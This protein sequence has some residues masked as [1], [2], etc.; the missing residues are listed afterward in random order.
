MCIITLFF[1]FLMIRR[2]PRSTLFP[3]T[4][5]FRSNVANHP[6]PGQSQIEAGDRLRERA[7]HEK[8]P[9]P[10]MKSR[11]AIPHAGDQL[12]RSGN[13]DHHGENNMPGKN[14]VAHRCSGLVSV[15]KDSIPRLKIPAQ[16]RKSIER[17][18]R[19]RERELPDQ[20]HAKPESRSRSQRFIRNRTQLQPRSPYRC[21]HVRSSLRAER[22]PVPLKIRL[23]LDTA[24]AAPLRQEISR[25]TPA[26]S[27][28]PDCSEISPE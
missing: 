15:G 16:R 1:F 20:S 21:T 8:A 23:V 27:T 3:Y 25:R 9:I 7:Q 10:A 19:K 18:Y 11:E 24:A 28:A 5:L 6:S 12:Q 4:T 13:I 26:R 14:G 17:R 22:N 2:P